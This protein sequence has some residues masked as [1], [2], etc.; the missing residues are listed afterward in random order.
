MPAVNLG[1]AGRRR[2]LVTGLAALAA[3]LLA[4]VPLVLAPVSPGWRALLIVPFAV[5]LLGLGQARTGT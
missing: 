2:R 3:G 5:G 1:R 4:A